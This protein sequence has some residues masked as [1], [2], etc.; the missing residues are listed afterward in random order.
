MLSVKRR[1]ERIGAGCVEGGGQCRRPLQGVSLDGLHSA[2]RAA[3]RTERVDRDNIVGFMV[4]GLCDGRTA[5]RSGGNRNRR[6][7][8]YQSSWGPNYLYT[9]KIL[10]CST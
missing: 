10:N 3:R 2:S 5:S 4:V 9:F 7:D 1:T 6:H 8:V